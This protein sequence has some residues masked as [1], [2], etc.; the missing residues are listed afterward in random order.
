MKDRY[1][2]C[3]KEKNNDGKEEIYPI[4]ESSLIYI[5]MYTS[6]KHCL[7]DR[8]LYKLLPPFVL[9]FINA[10]FD[11]KYDSEYNFF[12]R[13]SCNNIRKGRTDLPILY[14]QDADIVYANTDDIFNAL[15]DMKIEEDN[16]NSDDEITKIKKEFFNIMYD[17]LFNKESKM[18]YEID[19][20]VEKY[21]LFSTRFKSICT[22]SFN[23]E[24]IA[25]YVSKDYLLKRKF[26]LLLKEY[27]KKIDDIKGVKTWLVEEK[28]LDARQN[29]RVFYINSAISNMKKLLDTQREYYSKNNPIKNTEDIVTKEEKTNTNS[30]SKIGLE[31]NPYYIEYM[32][33]FID[34]EEDDFYMSNDLDPEEDEED[35]FLGPK[36]PNDPRYRGIN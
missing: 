33:R 1:V 5:D 25:K 21:D 8:D 12:I 10:N 22:K 26:L 4:Y 32:R 9:N 14:K 35:D 24:L 3:F 27:K 2:L 15:N 18:S 31:N 29:N 11:V 20:K 23:L 34:D 30:N 16:Y 36:K 19:K 17:M 13:K 6:Y 28:E 7:S